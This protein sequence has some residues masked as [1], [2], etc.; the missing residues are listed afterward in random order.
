M[1]D[2]DIIES[3]HS[4]EVPF[5]R[6]QIA[7]FLYENLDEF[8]DAREHILASIAYAYGE[9][10]GQDGFVLVASDGEDIVG[11][12]VINDTNMGG[13]IPEHILV[14][15]ATHSDY[16]GQGV[17]SRMMERILEHTEGDVALHVEQDNPAR[18]L[19]EK[20]DFTNKYLEYRHKK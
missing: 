15:I 1:I 19:Y 7:D 18:H 4:G 12:V 20:Y 3:D 16:R 2:L 11:T 10:A 14:Y 5:T 17:G 6:D 9:E 8:G 13:Y